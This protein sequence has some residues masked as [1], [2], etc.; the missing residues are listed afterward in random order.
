MRNHSYMCDQLSSSQ[1]ILAMLDCYYLPL[2]RTLVIMFIF[3]PWFLILVF[4]WDSIGT[5]FTVLCSYFWGLYTVEGEVASYLTVTAQL[6]VT[7]GKCY[8]AG[9]FSLLWI[10]LSS[11]ECDDMAPCSLHVWGGSHEYVRHIPCC[12]WMIMNCQQF[13][14][15][16]GKECN[17][18]VLCIPREETLCLCWS[19]D[20]K[21]CER[22]WSWV[23]CIF[24]VWSMFSSVLCV[25]TFCI[26]PWLEYKFYLL[27]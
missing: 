2:V 15:P 14:E 7:A 12:R 18:C 3:I 25:W 6:F 8:R 27:Q 11:Q 10:P 16:N 20:C 4:C 23:D 19:F 22:L 5:M 1:Y 9:L 24:R 17:G 26:L 13:I 21:N